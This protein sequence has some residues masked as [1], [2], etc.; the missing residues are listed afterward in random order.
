MPFLLTITPIENKVQPCKAHYDVW[1]LFHTNGSNFNNI[2]LTEFYDTKW[3]TIKDAKK[4]V[5]DQCNLSALEF[6]EKNL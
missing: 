1:Y 3:L 6:V 4:I 2:D 5:T